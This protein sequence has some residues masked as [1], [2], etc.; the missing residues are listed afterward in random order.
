M[1]RVAGDIAVHR[2]FR[3]TLKWAMH[4]PLAFTCSRKCSTFHYFEKVKTELNRLE[5]FFEKKNE[6]VVYN[7]TEQSQGFII[8]FNLIGNKVLFDIDT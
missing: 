7:Y 5:V 1:T 2:C 8:R 4:L 3:T 6:N